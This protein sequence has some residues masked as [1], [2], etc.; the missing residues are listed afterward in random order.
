MILTPQQEELAPVIAGHLSLKDPRLLMI[1]GLSEV[2]KSSLVRSVLDRMGKTAV[3][4]PE[5]SHVDPSRY[6]S[7]DVAVFDYSNPQNVEKIQEALR[8]KVSAFVALAHPR[9]KSERGLDR[10]DHAADLEA[11]GIPSKV[12]ALSP[13]N[14]PQ[15]RD[16][17]ASFQPNPRAAD[18]VD[19]YGLGIAGH[20]RRLLNTP[21][22]DHGNG[23]VLGGAKL[24]QILRHSIQYSRD[25]REKLEALLGARLPFAP[26]FDLD[27]SFDNSL[28]RSLAFLPPD[29]E[30]QVPRFPETLAMYRQLLARECDR[31]ELFVPDLDPSL[32]QELGVKEDGEFDSKGRILRFANWASKAGVLTPSII[33]ADERKRWPIDEFSTYAA[34]KWVK[35]E[36]IEGL[37]LATARAAY[38]SARS[39]GYP[40]NR[41]EAPLFPYSV[42]TLLQARGVSYV[43]D[44]YGDAPTVRHFVGAEGVEVL[45]KIGK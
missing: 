34:R 1:E 6:L 19:L 25:G 44:Y 9:F 36:S 37:P 16:Y 11:A 43:A 10:V 32:L 8:D 29:L 17:I 38:F 27:S 24:R 45:E 15:S 7:A 22:L 41:L 12:L 28:E 4:I 2:G 18:L 31:I 3:T 39:H 26:Q 40:T 30:P 13:M 21:E 14:P 23:N 35:G 20:I 33:A 5:Y 42:E